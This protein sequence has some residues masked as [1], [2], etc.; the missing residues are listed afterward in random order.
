M[1][2]L[3]ILGT[4]PEAIKL[5]PLILKTIDDK[6]FVPRLCVTAQHRE[7]LDQVLRVFRIKPHYDLN[8]MKENQSLFEVTSKSLTAIEGVLRKEKPDM[9]IV[10]GDTTSTFT[11]SLASFYLKIPVGHVEAGLRTNYKYQPFPEEINRRLT[12]HIADLHFAPTNKARENLL[13]EGI[14][15]DK[16]TVTGNTA[17]DALLH[18]KTQLASNRKKTEK[19]KKEFPMLDGT[20]VLVTAHRRESFGEGF[21]NICSALREIAQRNPAITIIYPV[22]LNPNVRG[23]VMRILKGIRNIHLIEPLEYETFVYLMMKSYIILTDS[24]G[25]QEE[26]PSLGKPVLVMRDV[27]ERKEAISAGVARL[28]GTKKT[29]IV[30]AV[31]KLIYDKKAYREM[32]GH[33]NPYGDGLASERIIK[34]LWEFKKKL[35]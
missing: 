12:T 23:P 7:M 34:A 6:R 20:L 18:I 3:F 29:S 9:V 24:G 4:R 10:Q 16:I 19:L 32:T 13:K 28:V 11:A 14:S 8:I 35:N 33:K 5:A 2:I 22:H 17:V 21:K 1:K 27:T 26:A 15:K 25:I 30:K 31:E